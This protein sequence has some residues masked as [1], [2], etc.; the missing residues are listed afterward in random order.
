MLGCP[1]CKTKL[2]MVSA[3]SFTQC[4]KEREE[5]MP[6]NC[7]SSYCFPHLQYEKGKDWH[8]F[9]GKDG[10]GKQ[11][12]VRSLLALRRVEKVERPLPDEYFPVML[13]DLV[14]SRC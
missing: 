2:Q 8:L 14:L 4:S 3:G 6:M 11:T 7:T 10:G 13:Q 5:E 1:P 12:K 9:K